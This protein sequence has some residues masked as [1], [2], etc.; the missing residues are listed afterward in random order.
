MF[1]PFGAEAA[2]H[3]DAA[4]RPSKGANES[5]LRLCKGRWQRGHFELRG[6]LPS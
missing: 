3:E 4:L 1:F 5:V 6:A 2:D